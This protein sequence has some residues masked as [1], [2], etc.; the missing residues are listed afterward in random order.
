MIF[1]FSIF[2]GLFLLAHGQTAVRTIAGT[3]IY[4]DSK[5]FW[6][7]NAP[8]ASDADGC[9]LAYNAADNGIDYLAN[10]GSPGNWWGITVNPSTRQPY[11][12]TSQDPVPGNYITS[13]SLA[14]KLYG[15]DRQCRFADACKLSF[16]VIPNS[17]SL[18]ADVNVA[19]G[20]FG[21]VVY[22]NTL[23]YTMYADAGPADKLGEGSIFLLDSVTV[24]AGQTIWNK[25][26]SRVVSGV[27]SGV[28]F[29]MF[30][31]S[32]FGQGYI[33][34]N[35][36]IN[37]H[38]AGAFANWGG[39]AR[40][41]QVVPGL[42]A[43]KCA[44]IDSPNILE[45][46]DYKCGTAGVEKACSGGGVCASDATCAGWGGSLVSGTAECA[47]FP[48]NIKCCTV[49]GPSGGDGTRPITTA[50][51][52]PT[53]VPGATSARCYALA[54]TCLDSSTST[55][56]SGNFVS[57]LCPGTPS[58][59]RCCPDEAPSHEAVGRACNGNYGGSRARCLD[60]DTTQCR[61]DFV[62]GKCDGP[63]NVKCCTQPQ[64][65]SAGSTKCTAPNGKAGYCY[66]TTTCAQ[67][68]GIG[69]TSSTCGESTKCCVGSSISTLLEDDAAADDAQDNQSATGEN[70][71]N[72][73][74]GNVNGISIALSMIVMIMTM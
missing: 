26:K 37:K 23:I 66:G 11:V 18:R 68:N 15:P 3:T 21:I 73:S 59:I 20:D 33:P 5:A 27:A 65:A 17:S 40:L 74:N 61:V 64:S 44:S 36:D 52:A 7:T 35:R 60:T 48:S 24:P 14:N 34:T 31:R 70:N 45:H 38:A 10:A 13:T 51:P 57:G 29:I 30:P 50:A 71:D 55:C 62:S 58:N 47:G 67:S 25:A 1:S 19:I 46:L 2:C 16:I 53:T 49:S 63:A 28:S 12:Q 8:M 56:A 4:K 9:A 22:K 6:F 54:G 41:I 43:A 39:C 42:T 72:S 32:G 69:Y